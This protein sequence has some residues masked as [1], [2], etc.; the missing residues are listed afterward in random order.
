MANE[1]EIGQQCVIEHVNVRRGKNDE[2]E[3]AIDI[4][5]SVEDLPA[6]AAAAALRAEHVKEVIAAFFSDGKDQEKRFLGIGAIP[7]DEQW[8]GKHKIKISSLVSM[9]VLKLWKVKLRP[10]AKGLFDGEFQ[11]TVEQP[12]QNYIE[13]V[14]DKL[15]RS[16]Q[17]KLEQD[18]REL[19]LKVKKGEDAAAE[20]KKPGKVTKTEPTQQPL[21][22]N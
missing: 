19:D 21:N 16:V 14:A 5:F 4:K 6:K 11:V 10:R 15:H 2:S 13:A 8:E 9:R 20:A 22:V 7:I 17:V 3:V 1:F 12:P 18:V